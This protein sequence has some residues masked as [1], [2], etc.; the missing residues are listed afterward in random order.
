MSRELL[1]GLVGTGLTLVLLTVLLLRAVHRQERIA[2]RLLEVQRAVGID[3]V[4]AP[5]GAGSIL[6]DVIGSVGSALTRTSLLSGKTVADLE[7]TLMSAGFRGDRALGIFVGAKVL[8]LVAL[9]AAAWFGLSWAG[10]PPLQRNV[11]TAAAAI[12]GLLAPDAIA[13]RLRQRYL[14]ELERGLPDALDMMVICAEAGLGLE[15]AM[16][17]TAEEIGAANRPVAQEF[18]LTCSEL[19]ILS[20]RRQAILNLGE[21]TGLDALK[22]FSATLVQTIQYGTP[23]TLALRTL[24]AEMRQDSLV[25]F[26]ARAARLPVLLTM[27]MILFILPTVFL[28]I[29]GP[30]FLS[31]MKVR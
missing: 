2:A 14:A 11:L 22:R 3:R 25:R 10:L 24:S 20:D 13:R 16:E 5:R 23:L 8:L 27:P 18:G 6:L 9:P 31:V 26:E 29:A 15:T 21:R 30:A 28:V 7:Q 19:R 17:R 12:A 1:L 4:R